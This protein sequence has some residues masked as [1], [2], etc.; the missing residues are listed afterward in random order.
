MRFVRI[1]RLLTKLF[2]HGMISRHVFSTATSVYLQSITHRV[3]SKIDANV[4]AKGIECAGRSLVS[5]ELR[6]TT[7]FYLLS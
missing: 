4:I 3:S 1:S 6:S 7:I 5:R 2:G